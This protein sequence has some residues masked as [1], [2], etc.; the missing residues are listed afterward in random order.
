MKL[1]SKTLVVI[2]LSLLIPA[3]SGAATDSATDSEDTGADQEGVTCQWNEIY[4]YNYS[5]NTGVYHWDVSYNF[6][7]GRWYVD[8]RRIGG[9][10][11]KQYSLSPSWTVCP[12]SIQQITLQSGA[13]VL[14]GPHNCLPNGVEEVH[15]E[16]QREL[17][18]QS[19]FV[20]Y[21]CFQ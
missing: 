10:F 11:Y 17:V 15:L 1:W 5:D 14:A 3:C 19:P 7:T 21:E 4:H 9:G 13:T 20:T 18:P 2:A 12:S 8:E 6:T 16:K